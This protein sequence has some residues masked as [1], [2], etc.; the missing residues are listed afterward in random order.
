MI[1]YQAKHKREAKGAL[2]GTIY[3][4]EIADGVLSRSNVS[5]LPRTVAIAA[6]QTSGTSTDTAYI[7][8][9]LYSFCYEGQTSDATAGALDVRFNPTTGKIDVYCEA[10]ATG[11]VGVSVWIIKLTA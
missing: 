9:A 7:G 3:G 8:C 1:P 5:L 6:G 2:T 11:D 4:D 10:A